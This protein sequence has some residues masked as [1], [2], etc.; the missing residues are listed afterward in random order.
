MS[1]QTKKN[2]GSKKK[3]ANL[4]LLNGK[5]FQNYVKLVNVV[6]LRNGEEVRNDENICQY[7]PT[8]WK[9]ILK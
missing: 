1:H 3:I 6:K 5:E 4:F 8:I 9:R 7:C 2:L